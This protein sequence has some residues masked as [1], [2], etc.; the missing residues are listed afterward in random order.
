MIFSTNLTHSY[1]YTVEYANSFKRDYKR[2]KKRG[3]GLKA[4]RQIIG[5]LMETGTLPPQYRP[6]KLTGQYAGLWEAHI[7]PD[8]LLVWAQND[9]VLTLL[10]TNTGTHADLFG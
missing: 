6:H 9:E 5:M 3:Y 7:K 8:W 1:M 10:M 2:C 4:L